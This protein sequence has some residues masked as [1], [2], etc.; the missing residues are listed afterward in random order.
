MGRAFV[1]FKLMILTM[2]VTGSPMATEDQLNLRVEG[3][4]FV[5][6]RSVG[7]EGGPKQ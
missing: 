1:L 4:S 3:V 7:V 6:L 2:K 5:N